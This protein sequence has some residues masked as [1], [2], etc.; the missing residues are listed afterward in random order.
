[1]HND[2]QISVQFGV[3]VLQNIV[4]AG[5]SFLKDELPRYDKFAKETERYIQYLVERFG[6]VKVLGMPRPVP[7]LSLYV[8][9]NILEK[10]TSRSGARV[11]DLE[12]FFDL[13]RRAFGVKLETKDCEEIV[14]DLKQFIVL[15]KPG[16]GKT[17]FLRYLTLAMIHEQSQI[18][19]RRLPIF[20]ALRDWADKRCGLVE[21]ITEQFIDCDFNQAKPFVENIL[22]QGNCIVLFDGLDEVSQEANLD[23]IIR[24]IRDFSE[25]Y[26]KNQF[27]MSCRVAAYNHWFERFIDVEMADFNEEQIEKFVKNWFITEPKTA[28]E[29]FI[30]LK[31]TPQLRE[32]SSVPLLLTLLCIAYDEYNDFPTNRAELYEDA[33]DA[34]LRKWD[35]SRRISRDDPY[36][37]LSV[38]Q[39]ENMFARIAYGA[40]TE[41]RYFIRKKDLTKMIGNFISNLPIFKAENIELDSIEVLRTI[42]SNHG[43]FVER[44]KNIHSF[45]H[46]SFQEYFTAK[47]IVDNGYAEIE[48]LVNKHLY[49]YKWNEVFLLVAGMLPDADELLLLM[50]KKNRNILQEPSLN[51]MMDIATKAL[52]PSEDKYSFELRKAIV[53]FL[54]IDSTR[55]RSIGND[56]ARAR[57]IDFARA[58][59]LI[60][61][62]DIDK[63]FDLARDLAL[64]LVRGLSVDLDINFTSID[65]K[66]D[67]GIDPD[68]SVELGKELS[69]ITLVVKKISD[70]LKGNIL[71]V[72]CLNTVSYISNTTREYVLS[73]MLAPL[74]EHEQSPP[75]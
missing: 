68:L 73:Q 4:S 25:K 49:D 9:A 64:D 60:R 7:L 37:Q 71:I 51:N 74:T 31:A 11:E 67:P 41:N 63:V 54:T 2:I 32:L 8:R 10:I 12:K 62:Q 75:Q 50:L 61:N 66:I 21:Y 23:G 52:L 56:L 35:S 5:Y 13:D 16:A 69:S 19:K 59:D 28:E 65:P 46:L 29:C 17:T 58:R 48:K 39:K 42:E 40:F 15:G 24:A 20:I 47:Y 38:K 72:K 57:D 27:V 14:N 45:A 26:L 55:A 70:F 33:I 53:L 43:I 22:K 1:M 34:L 6:E 36:K 30:H 44:A 18:K 3:S